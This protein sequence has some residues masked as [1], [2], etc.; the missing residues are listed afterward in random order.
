ME[1]QRNVKGKMYK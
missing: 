1:R